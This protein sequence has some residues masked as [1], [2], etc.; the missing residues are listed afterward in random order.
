MKKIIITIVLVLLLIS[1]NKENSNVI[2][3]KV[4]TWV[5]I[6]K[7]ST[8][9]L[10]DNLNIKKQ[11][12][13]TWNIVDK[14]LNNKTILSW[15]IEIINIDED[16][17]IENDIENIDNKWLVYY[18]DYY[19]IFFTYPKVNN[20]Y[21][22]K[23]RTIIEED[24]VNNKILITT[25][26]SNPQIINFIY[27]VWGIDKLE[28]VIQKE[29]DKTCIV[30]DKKKNNNWYYDINLWPSL[31][32]DTDSMPNCFL[33][34]NMS[35][36]YYEEEWFLIYSIIWQ[37]PQFAFDDFWS[38][39][40]KKIVNSFNF[41]NWS[42]KQVVRKY[43]WNGLVLKQDKDWFLDNNLWRTTLYLNDKAL[44]SLVNNLS[45]IN[46]DWK[47]LN[48]CEWYNISDSIIK[49]KVVDKFK[50]LDS[51]NKDIFIDINSNIKVLYIYWYESHEIYFIDMK[52]EKIIKDKLWWFVKSIKQGKSWT[53]ILEKWWRGC[54]WWLIFISNKWDIN[55]LFENK[56]DEDLDDSYKEI[57]DFELMLNKQIKI[58]Y[59]GHNLED[60]EKIIK[61]N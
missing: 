36:K 7:V 37:E 52:N 17:N 24:L 25:E 46:C 50:I 56:C 12:I 42:R 60:K 53:F 49:N 54:S 6:D 61:L 43:Y 21:K 8:W 9:V 23:K 38:F 1:C 3:D 58:F 29:I 40:D 22:L 51:S 10:I 18:S 59:K 16:K 27:E 47:P 48:V 28:N 55:Y 15:S 11:E 4:S 31:S 5:L 19:N 44:I 14:E 2:I 57:I 45:T 20:A 13:F 33:N 30:K 39:V 35:L 34:F 26:W 32:W 41:F